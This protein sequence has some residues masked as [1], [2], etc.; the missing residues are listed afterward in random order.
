M[1]V[2]RRAFLFGA[3]AVPQRHAVSVAG[4]RCLALSGVVC[5]NCG[6][7]CDTRAIQ[8]LYATGG[9][10]RPVVDA[11]RCTACGDCLSVCPA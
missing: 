11:Q 8:F 9:V 7:A 2:S 4:E 1:S 5:R 3:S 6:D 10:P